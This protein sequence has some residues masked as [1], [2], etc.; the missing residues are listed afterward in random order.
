MSSSPRRRLSSIFQECTA[1][2]TVCPLKQVF[3]PAGIAFFYAILVGYYLHYGKAMIWALIGM[4]SAAAAAGASDDRTGEG[5]ARRA[6]PC[7]GD[8]ECSCTGVYRS[9]ALGC[10]ALRAK[11]KHVVRQ[12]KKALPAAKNA[13]WRIAV[14]AAVNVTACVI[15]AVVFLWAPVCFAH[16]TAGVNNPI[17]NKY[18]PDEA[19]AGG[20]Y[21][22]EIKTA[23]LQ[24]IKDDACAFSVF[25]KDAP[26]PENLYGLMYPW[27]FYLVP[28]LVPGLVILY[29][30]CPAWRTP[31]AE[32][33]ATRRA[34]AGMAVRVLRRTGRYKTSMQKYLV[35]WSAARRRHRGHGDRGD[36]GDGD[37]RRR[38]LLAAAARD[39]RGRGGSR[40]GGEEEGEDDEVPRQL[41]QL[42]CQEESN[43]RAEAEEETAWV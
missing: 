27:F 9:I 29:V 36:G 20:L 35:A 12:Y 21:T 18:Q 17:V 22:C 43:G 5:G 34:P 23:A 32:R 30:M 4:G 19:A 42:A 13:V 3:T 7:C 11:V 28:E 33:E 40:G 38:P 6:R 26:Y 31:P 16:K 2:R 39:R 25:D 24:A 15:G 1:Y 8:C 41:L 14:I 10:D 37:A